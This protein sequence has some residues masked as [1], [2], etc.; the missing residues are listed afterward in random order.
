[1]SATAN[2]FSFRRLT[3]AKLSNCLL[4]NIGPV[5]A[6]DRGGKTKTVNFLLAW[7][8]F[9]GIP[10][11]RIDSTCGF[12]MTVVERFDRFIDDARNHAFAGFDMSEITESF[13]LETISAYL[14][15]KLIFVSTSGGGDVLLKFSVV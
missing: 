10:G 12:Y 6:V 13:V 11:R 4:K 1:V 14:E 9:L 3:P 2:V 15:Q 8:K 5:P 7:G